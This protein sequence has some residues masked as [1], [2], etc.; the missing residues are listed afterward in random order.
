M[1]PPKPHFPRDLRF[2]L[3]AVFFTGALAAA[4]VAPLDGIWLVEEG[5]APDSMPA[6]FSHDE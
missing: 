3:A 4:Q 1:K 2:S 5:V 6:S